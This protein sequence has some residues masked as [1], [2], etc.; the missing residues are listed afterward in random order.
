M[1]LTL[2]DLTSNQS[3]KCPQADYALFLKHYKTPHYPFQGGVGTALDVLACCVPLF[4]WKLKLPFLSPPISISVFQFVYQCTDVA[5]VSTTKKLSH[6]AI[7]I[8]TMYIYTYRYECV[9]L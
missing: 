4:A 8:I 2:N 6:I 3:G 7:S 5:N 1:T 9:K